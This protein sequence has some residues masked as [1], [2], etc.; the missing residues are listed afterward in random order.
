[1]TDGGRWL[2]LIRLTT[3]RELLF[4]ITHPN[5]MSPLCP[6]VLCDPWP[7]VSH[8]S[9]HGQPEQWT[10]AS[11]SCSTRKG[12]GQCLESR[13]LVTLGSLAFPG[14]P[15]H[16]HPFI[17]GR[18]F[19]GSRMLCVA[20]L[21]NSCH[22]FV[23]CS[24]H[25]TFSSRERRHFEHVSASWVLVNVVTKSLNVRARREHGDHVTQLSV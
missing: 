22:L 4:V 2:P 13:D 1:M 21:A 9:L 20:A 25:N 15:T 16:H 12:C 5:G 19:W 8:G 10:S 18:S 23:L 11:S 3:T 6:M 24:L 14:A 17:R 7:S